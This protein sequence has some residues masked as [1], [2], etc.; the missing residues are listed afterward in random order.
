ME[1]KREERERKN[2]NKQPPLW[3]CY[4]WSLLDFV[5]MLLDLAPWCA[6]LDFLGHSLVQDSVSCCL[7]LALGK[8]TEALL[9]GSL[10]GLMGRGSL[11]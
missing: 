11:A 10:C 4:L 7:C 5:S 8:L 1:S 9:D 6:V 2:K 3:I